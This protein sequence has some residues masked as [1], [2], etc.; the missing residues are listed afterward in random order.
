MQRSLDPEPYPQQS[1]SSQ[2]SNSPAQITQ[3]NVSD[4]SPDHV[5]PGVVNTT[6]VTPA[7]TPAMPRSNVYSSV[8][9]TS[10]VTTDILSVLQTSLQQTTLQHS[11]LSNERPFQFVGMHNYNFLVY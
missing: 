9:K 3:A 10:P 7:V 11:D 6:T 5:P 8:Q 4:G 2:L 1:G